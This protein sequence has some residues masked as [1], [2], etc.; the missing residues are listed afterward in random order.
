[1][2]KISTEEEVT[3]GNGKEIEEER[4][5]DINLSFGQ[6]NSFEVEEN[7]IEFIF[8]GFVTEELKKDENITMIVNLIKG[9]ELVEEEVTCISQEDVIPENGKQ[10][11][12]EFEC[13]LENIEK[14]EEYTGL[15]IVE[16]DEVS[17]IPTDPKLLNPGEVD[18]LIEKGKIKNYKS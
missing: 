12:V 4:M 15:E 2:N 1:M 16:S 18:K 5:Y 17:G 14:A 8:I 3:I 6:V 10:F 7:I 13:K 9:K 11:P